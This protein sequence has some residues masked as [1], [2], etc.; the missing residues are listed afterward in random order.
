MSTNNRSMQLPID[1]CEEWIWDTLDSTKDCGFEYIKDGN[2]EFLIFNT[3]ELF[4]LVIYFRIFRCTYILQVPSNA[5]IHATL[6]S[7]IKNA[8]FFLSFFC[9]KS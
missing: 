7:C 2:S 6:V 9:F 4:A 1:E 8:L 3:N 5:Y